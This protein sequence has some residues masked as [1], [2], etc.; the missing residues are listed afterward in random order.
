[1]CLGSYLSY[2][3]PLFKHAVRKV[4]MGN[5]SLRSAR[6]N[7]RL[8]ECL[9]LE[10]L[11]N[12]QLDGPILIITDALGESGLANGKAGLHTFLAQCLIDLPPNFYVLTISRLENGIE[13]A[14]AN[15]NSV[16]TL[17]MVDVQL[18][19]NT[20][21]DIC[22]YLRHEHPRGGFKHHGDNLVKASEGLFQWAAVAC[23]FINGPISLSLSKYSTTPVYEFSKST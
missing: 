11:M 14:F 9:L 21:P 6:D 5:M 10:P 23:G 22:L 8:F 2:R 1:M 7:P 4:V 18:A 12:L 3:Y 19:A 20:E 17:Y 13:P 15:A 16:R